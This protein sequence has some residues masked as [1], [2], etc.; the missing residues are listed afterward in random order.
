MTFTS[1]T[2]YAAQQPLFAPAIITVLVVGFLAI[3]EYVRW[4][5]RIPGFKGPWSRPVVGN[6]W[7]IRHINAS[8]QY[9]QWAKR[10]GSVYQIQL[11][12]IPV[13]VVNSAAAAKAIFS[14]N[15]HAV[16]SRPEFYTFHKVSSMAKLLPL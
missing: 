1:I 14:Q 10:Y 12:N 13:L 15:S 6:L 3:H 16:S 8:E 4:S 7:Q 11:G 5:V 9:R 2:Q